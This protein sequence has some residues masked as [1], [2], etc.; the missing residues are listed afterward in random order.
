MIG[1]KDTLTL[2]TELFNTNVDGRRIANGWPRTTPAASRGA[3]VIRPSVRQ[4]V[5]QSVINEITCPTG[6]L[7]LVLS[8]R[9]WHLVLVFYSHASNISIRKRKS[10]NLH[11]M[12]EVSC[13]FG[14][15]THSP[16]L[17]CCRF[18][19]VTLHLRI[20]DNVFFFFCFL[21]QSMSMLSDIEFSFL[22]SLAFVIVIL[23]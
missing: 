4:S 2:F 19:H 12:S 13:S 1:K 16:W 10:S 23:K 15:T 7:P 22:V 17:S 3:P 11:D 5:R 18:F 8:L 21:G 14:S 6:E 9:L 20:N